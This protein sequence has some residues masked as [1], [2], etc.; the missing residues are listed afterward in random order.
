MVAPILIVM[1]LIDLSAAFILVT[2]PARATVSI[3]S[4]PIPY[5]LAFYFGIMMLIKGIYS[6]IWG[7]IGA[8]A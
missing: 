7:I 5:G 4:F 6:I 2:L 1:S 8:D 3:L